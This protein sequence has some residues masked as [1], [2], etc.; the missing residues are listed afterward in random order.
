ML[1]AEPA[2]QLGEVVWRRVV[3]FRD[4]VF[5]VEN[6]EQLVSNTYQLGIELHALRPSAS[7]RRF[8]K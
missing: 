2:I 1:W 4:A 6:E 5:P 3:F 8:T 7:L